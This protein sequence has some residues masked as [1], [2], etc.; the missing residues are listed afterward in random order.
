MKNCEIPYLAKKKFVGFVH[1][2]FKF[3][4]SICRLSYRFPFVP[5]FLLILLPILDF[6]PSDD[7]G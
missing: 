4:P 6:F 7:I 2:D 3:L 5:I 1:S